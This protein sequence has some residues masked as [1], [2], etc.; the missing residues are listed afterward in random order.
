MQW[1]DY[2]SNGGEGSI[3]GQGMKFPHAMRRGRKT[4][5]EFLTV[6]F[7]VIFLQIHVVVTATL[8]KRLFSTH[9]SVKI[10]YELL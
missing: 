10:V 3:P 9:F 8:D 5:S 2:P 6:L 4:E 7:P 1:P